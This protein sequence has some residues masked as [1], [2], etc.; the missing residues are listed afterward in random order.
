MPVR[1]VRVNPVVDMFAPVVRPTGNL[2]IVGEAANGTD[3]VPV[4]VTSPTDATARFGGP[5]VSA[6][7]KALHV[8]FEQAPG[9]SQV[10]GVKAGADV[11]GALAAVEDLNVQF[12]V[13]A[14]TALDADSGQ[15][16]GSI[17][18][19]AAHVKA[20]SQN[21]DGKERMGV[22]MLARDSADPSVVQGKLAMDRM[23]YVAHKS[24]DDVAAAV[25]AV[26]AGH[27]PSVSMVLKPVGVTSGSFTAAEIDKING[28]ETDSTPPA[29]Q[30]VTWL[31][32]PPLL[33]G[34]GVHL[35]EGYTGNPNGSKYIDVVRT[36]DDV[37]FRL[38][39]RLIK[40]VGTL[41]ISRS[42]LRSLVLQMDS[43]LGPLVADEVI[44]GYVVTIPLLRLLD[45]DPATL[46]K[47]QRGEIDQAQTERLAQV[48]V[49]VDYAGAMHRISID[50]KFA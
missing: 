18:K 41:R 11:T 15:D 42:G 25:A 3:G 7:T 44:E 50:L 24:A 6:L 49:S 33:P 19:L 31:V 13:V 16:D 14:G 23:V 5:E 10:W 48:L 46:S 37:S 27:G 35:G 36:V 38:K 12:V 1:Y 40:A 34:A 39:A 30:G 8:A 26:I 4:Q 2:A 22:A 20:V 43:V 47:E 28:A 9:P 29:G 17:G 32:D 21:G 45:A